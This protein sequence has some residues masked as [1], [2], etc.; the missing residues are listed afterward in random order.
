[1]G[2][3]K[4]TA[5]IARM[6]TAVR[7][8]S[9]DAEAHLVMVDGEPWYEWTPETAYNFEKQ[10]KGW[11]VRVKTRTP[12]PGVEAFTGFPREV[13]RDGVT[14]TVTAPGAEPVADGPV[15][16]RLIR[17]LKGGT[18]W[19]GI[20]SNEEDRVASVRE[21]IRFYA[22]NRPVADIT[23]R[24]VAGRCFM[25]DINGRPTRPFTRLVAKFGGWKAMKE[26]AL[27]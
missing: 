11:R 26:W 5:R 12:V 18:G 27:R 2:E 19:G 14:V 25:V 7:R 22:Q 6:K 10:L 8:K 20:P 13:H 3:L 9:F 17:A 1:V 23:Q 15:D 21:A 4:A 16:P 24:A